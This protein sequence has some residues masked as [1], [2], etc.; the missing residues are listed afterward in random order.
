MNYNKTI[1]EDGKSVID[2]AKLNNIEDQMES[3]SRTINVMIE[4]LNNIIKRLETI[5]KN[6]TAGYV[7]PPCKG[8]VD[9]E[10][11]T[12]FDLKK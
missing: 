3:H 8:K 12:L 1:W 5:E 10:T 2:A 9:W 6:A 7:D 11:T 4:N